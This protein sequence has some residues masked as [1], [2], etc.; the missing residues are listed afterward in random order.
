MT[1]T[2]NTN[3][4]SNAA[5][6]IS[7]DIVFGGLG[8]AGDAV[9]SV[10]QK[11]LLEGFKTAAQIGD[12][13]TRLTIPI[14][15]LQVSGAKVISAHG[16]D[17][18]KITIAIRSNDPNLVAREIFSTGMG[19]VATPLGVKLGGLIFATAGPVGSI[20]GGAGAGLISNSI[21]SSYAGDLWDSKLK[22][23][24]AGEWSINQM[25]DSFGIGIKINQG[26][27]NTT[28][29][30]TDIPSAN[31]A[32]SSALIFDP[33]DRQTKIIFNQNTRPTM[34]PDVAAGANT[35]TVQKGDSLWRIAQSNGWDLNAL[36][37]LN[38]QLSDPNFICTGQLINGMSGTGLPAIDNTRSPIIS[39]TPNPVAQTKI[40]TDT[41]VAQTINNGYTEH[42]ATGTV[43]LGKDKLNGSGFTESQQASLATGG[44]RP[45][46][47]QLDPNARPNTWLE[48][49]F[50]PYVS[51][52][53]NFGSKSDL[54]L[55]NAAA[56][57]SLAAGSTHQTFVDPILLDL[58]GKGVG[59]TN[60]ANNGVLFDVDH[61]GAL[62]RTGW[63]DAATGILV[64]D[65]GSGQ[66]T[67]VSQ[68]ISEYYGGSAGKDGA[69][70][71]KPFKDAFAALLAQD[72][73]HDGVIDHK[74]AIWN[75]LKV[76]I[77]ANHDGKVAEGELKTL[78]ALGITQI[79]LTTR[80]ATENE[81]RDGNRVLAHGSFMI[82][83]EVRDSVAE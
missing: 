23:S 82:N 80:T 48:Q 65:N 13:A 1:N 10:A 47:V 34:D 19:L 22:N 18:Y 53:S 6:D 45:G 67:D 64:N 8:R 38:P 32:P 20:L 36:T 27:L 70:G 74:D 26:S 61:S 7:V 17:A 51:G 28:P 52:P 78:D 24:A 69:A 5:Q 79:G 12:L 50:T 71:S 21:A 33:T 72:S 49:N 62:R 11:A 41:S 42:S 73:H 37:A 44:V 75:N 68:L 2:N 46:A 29:V 16:Y 31:I 25:T 77:D 3:Q 63:A 39:V 40:E 43:L 56:L 9:S 81:M 4:D 59:M 57:G 35:Y 14:A 60:Y 58:S 54:S 83:G 76:W 66:I 55:L 30:I 15:L